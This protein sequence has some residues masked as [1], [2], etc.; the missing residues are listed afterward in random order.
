MKS[1]KRFIS[2]LLAVMLV[3]STLIVSVPVSAEFTDLPKGHSAYEAVDVLS[4]LGVI[5]GYEENGSFNFKPDN[6]VTRAEFTAMLL[7]TRGMGAVGST[8]LENPPF[9]DVVTPDVSWAI[10]NIRTARELKII[11]G[12][13]DGTF[14]PNNNV[15]YEEAIKMI[16]CALGYG[17]MG[18]DGAFW[19]TRYL[20]TAT[21]LGFLEGAG[22]A[23]A[24]PA[25]RATI[26]SMLY[27]CL[28]IKLAE[29][30]AITDKTI[31]ENDL[32]LTKNVG[33][34]D[35]N[36]EISLSNPDSNLRDN[37][38]QIAV[39]T[40]SGVV[41]DTY[42]VENADSYK[43]MLG[44]QITF[45]YTLDRN[46]NFK[47]LIMAQVGNSKT[48]EIEASEIYDF[49]SSG[50]EYL[51]SADD[52]RTVKA[53]ISSNSVVVYNGKLYGTGV[54]DSTFSAYC[55]SCASKGSSAMP[56]IGK[57]KLLDRNND[58]S[59]D[60]V[61][62]DSYDAWVVSSKATSSYTITDNVLRKGLSDNKIVLDPSNT[63][64]YDASGSTSSFGAIQTGGVVCV[65]TSNDS[66]GG[67]LLKTA[68][69]CNDTVSGKVSGTSSD[70]TITIGGKKYKS[71][72][73][74]PWENVIS[75][76]T[77]D[78][79]TPAMGSNGKFYLDCDGNILAFDKT[80]AATN[81][82]YGYIT[83]AG[84]NDDDVFNPVT[85]VY[86]STKS[87]PKG[88][89]YTVTSKTKL[90][91]V[92]V[93]MGTFL[94][95]LKDA[96][97][98]QESLFPAAANGKEYAQLVKFTTSKGNE[99]DEIITATVQSEGMNI[100][101]D[102]L[103]FYESKSSATNSVTYDKTNRELD[104]IYIGD[105]L[106][107]GAPTVSNASLSNRDKYQVMSTSDFADGNNYSV[108]F[109]DVSGRDAARV[110]VVYSGAANLG[111]V[112]PNS[113]VLVIT[114]EPEH[115]D[116]T[117]LRGYVNGTFGSYTLSNEDDDTVA[118]A[119]DLAKGDVVRLGGDST[120]GYTVKE[121]NIIFSLNSSYRTGSYP[122]KAEANGSIYQIM[123]GSAYQKPDEVDNRFWI[124]NALLAEGETSTDTLKLAD[125]CFTST[126][127]FVLDEVNNTLKLIEDE[128]QAV[129]DSYIVTP[130]SGTPSEIFVHM[131]SYTSVK[132]M[133]I[134]NR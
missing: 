42:K 13:D 57:V 2:T 46:T 126:K 15:S 115:S 88:L 111:E 8:S 5:N 53:N 123:W 36:P 33:Y 32:K 9:P 69:V 78:T 80:E 131:T 98:A 99:I 43:D 41:V 105:A 127:F 94:G 125:S 45:Y 87:N 74:A 70:G 79:T 113:P 12:Y 89:P 52:S 26:A 75:G 95:D 108:G 59:Y 117:V 24:T 82:Q 104:G 103:K 119:K 27:N 51:K 97:D 19:Y 23:I 114:E 61:F 50:I 116:S 96:N 44:A 20:N 118:I 60:V 84:V 16:V 124:A 7:R 37:E 110:V 90:N 133:I 121:E 107:I 122:K 39:N 38:V 132:T 40:A 4:K 64:F 106:V 76:A 14:K 49:S 62:V 58:N 11:N 128:Y 55:E 65:K 93:N 22:G 48:I 85:I 71:S 67:T 35:S 28:E 73:Q 77:P 129:M 21:T 130:D 18:A 54:S 3:M 29:N 56:S 83:A 31:L 63:V 134:I 6:N 91:N 81:Q 120:N 47:H 102:E 34:I 25:T 30:N 86:I 1:T 101:T 109:Y 66:N 100:T 112:K 72:K 92:A 68:V 10:G 17:E